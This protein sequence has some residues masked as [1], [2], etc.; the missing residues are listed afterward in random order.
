MIC[1]NLNL[2]IF[3]KTTQPFSETQPNLYDLVKTQTNPEVLLATKL[4][5]YDMLETDPTLMICSKH[6]PTLKRSECYLEM[7]Y[8][9]DFYM[10]RSILMFNDFFHGK[11]NFLLR[12][13]YNFLEIKH[14]YIRVGLYC[15]YLVCR[16]VRD[17]CCRFFHFYWGECLDILCNTFAWWI[18]LF[19]SFLT[20]LL[21]VNCAT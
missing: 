18:V 1:V 2:M 17:I 7:Y 13:S 9:H 12:I 16:F 8:K 15:S 11:I 4:N 21:P 6:S 19:L 20:Y 14:I 3:L 10:F 5:P